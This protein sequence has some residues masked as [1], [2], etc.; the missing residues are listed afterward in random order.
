MRDLVQV[1]AGVDIGGG[2]VK[3]FRNH[4]AFH[5]R[6]LCSTTERLPIVQIEGRAAFGA[7]R[8]NDGLATTG[9]NHLVIAKI[10]LACLGR[11]TFL[12]EQQT[13]EVNSLFKDRHEIAAVYEQY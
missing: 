11:V 8:S 12:P 1:R 13:C 3:V 6:E 4:S 9:Y 5:D 10:D 2:D 7:S